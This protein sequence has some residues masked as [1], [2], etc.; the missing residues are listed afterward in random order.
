MKI[1]DW[2][3]SKLFPKPKLDEAQVAQ[4]HAEF[5]RKAGLQQNPLIDHPWKK[6]AEAVAR[7]F[8]QKI[9]MAIKI[10][11]KQIEGK[12]PTKLDW[13]KHGHRIIMADF[14]HETFHWKDQPIVRVDWWA[15]AGQPFI[16]HTA[17]HFP[18]VPPPK[19]LDIGAP[20]S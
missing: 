13:A 5:V 2:I 10:T 12:E 19:K 4:A 16:I 18:A 14:T 3:K 9:D 7:D 8:A 1:L 11:V 20:V 6:L 17:P 15:K